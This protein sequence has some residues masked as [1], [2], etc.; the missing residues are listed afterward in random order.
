MELTTDM[1]LVMGL[2]GLA[3]FLFVVEWI[4]VDVVAIL[5]M[6]L[7]PLFGL[8]EQKH[9]FI[10]LGSNAVVAIIAV[11]ILGAGLDKTGVIN[12]IVSPVVRF[13]GKNPNRIIVAISSTVG[14]ISSFMQ[15]IGAA[16]LFLPAIKR[17][18]KSMN[19]SISRLLMPVGFAAIL[20]GTITMVG[21]SPLILL[22]DLLRPLNLEPFG[23]FDVTPI[24]LALLISGI[25]YFVLFGKFVLPQGDEDS[26][27]ALLEESITQHYEFLGEP[28][29][30]RTPKGWK[31]IPHTLREIRTN[32]G[33]S[34]VA[35]ADQDKEYT[36]A[37]GRESVL[38]PEIDIGVY[39]KPENVKRFADE[40]GIILK[41][42]LDFFK[43]LL[44]PSMSG[45]VEAVVSPHS[46]MEGKT[47]LH[48]NFRKKY[49]LVPMAIYRSKTEI[50]QSNLSDV[51]LKVGDAVLLH[52]SWDRLKI[53]EKN[54]NFII[55]SPI[56]TEPLRPEKSHLAVLWFAVSLSM[57]IFF[58]IQLS[59]S[60]MTG[61]LGIIITKVITIDEAYQSVDWRTV[62]LLGGLIPLGVATE[63]TGTAEWIASNIF[64]LVGIVS[65]ITLLLII[66]VLTSCFTLVISNIGATVLLVPL[67]IN[68]A[69]KTGTDP[70]MAALM[71]G[72]AASNSFILPTH[73]VNAL[74]MGPG[75]YRS[76][77]FIKAGTIQSIIFIVVTTA[78]MYLFYGV[79]H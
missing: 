57:V 74:Y 54:K 52:G 44:S 11:I 51:I 58:N 59:V 47:L 60:L 30:L 70:R 41:E 72:I 37:P 78:M 49:H 26:E 36:L 48:F 8:V 45:T 61:A 23:L 40:N 16:A 67:V 24:G 28:F 19:I 15:N 27:E 12:R 6:V 76:I 43:T 2:I 66:A 33:I 9:A 68:L 69:M 65:P 50:F 5:I 3:I 39:G 73:Q 56:E 25:G 13:A 55:A 10:G 4:R 17:I 35:I 77:D 1:I 14:T 75:R 71:V 46:Q 42:S 7:L 20:G 38:V 18:S 53:L 62:F 64:D 63:E 22:N 32:Y 29:E 31:S 79:Q 34:V 21:S